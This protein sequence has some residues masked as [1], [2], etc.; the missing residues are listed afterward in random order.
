MGSRPKSPSPFSGICRSYSS[1]LLAA[2]YKRSS[3]NGDTKLSEA[4]KR[5]IDG[6]HYSKYQN[7]QPWD[8]W[9]AWGLNPFQA[10]ILKHLVRYRD[11]GEP[12]LD[13]E[14]AKHYLEKLIE[15]EKEKD[16]ISQC[17]CHPLATGYNYTCP[18]HG[19]MD[20]EIERR[21]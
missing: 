15:V 21:R 16:T 2:P 13:L 5:Q 19:G 3:S 10:I 7:L 11:K 6:T 17:Q 8:V 18:V 20:A 12:L 9:M 1:I 4:N 14:K